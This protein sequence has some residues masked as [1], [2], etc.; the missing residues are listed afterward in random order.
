MTEI[1]A[2]GTRQRDMLARKHFLRNDML[3]AL[4]CIT[5]TDAHEQIDRPLRGTQKAL[6][7]AFCSIEREYVDNGYRMRVIRITPA[8]RDRV[9]MAI[10]EAFEA[11]A[12]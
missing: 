12:K 7:A 8:G 3:W 6:D 1:P 5:T 4:H 11:R 9:E 2:V 10:V